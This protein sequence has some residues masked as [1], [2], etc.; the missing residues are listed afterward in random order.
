MQNGRCTKSPSTASKSTSLKSPWP[1]TPP[2]STT[3]AATSASA[4]ASPASPPA[5]R[6]PTA[7]SSTTPSLATTSLDPAM[8]HTPINNVSWHGAD[9][10]CAWVDARLPTEAEWELAARGT[11]GRLYPWGNEAPDDT[12]ALFNATFD[13]LQPVDA[14]PDGDQPL[15]GLRFSRQRLGM[16]RRRVQR[17]LLRRKPRRK[18]RQ[19][20]RLPRHR[21][22]PARRQ[23]P[24]RCQR[25]PHHLPHPRRPHRLPKHPRRGLPLCLFYC[26]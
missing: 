16:G 4:T 6:P 14:L 17:H 25:T 22:R 5:S 2:S 9:A 20:L 21:P 24:Q 18:S 19:P 15:R 10:Y 3:K 11:D 1:N 26:Q 8:K 23:L 12:H 13:D 7:T